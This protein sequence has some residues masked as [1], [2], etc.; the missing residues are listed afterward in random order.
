[1]NKQLSPPVQQQY[2]NI[3]NQC[4]KKIAMVCASNQNR[5][6]EAHYLFVKT[7]FKNIRSFG[8]SGH[9][10]LPGPSIHQPNIFSFGTPY[11]EI[12]TTL[13]DQDQELYIKN[14]LLNMLERNKKVKLAPEKWQEE[15]NAKFDIVFTF[16]QRVYDAVI[17]DLAQRD[18]T[19]L[20]QPVHIIN[21]QVKDTHEEA[22]GGAQHALEITSIIENTEDW[23]DKLNDILE[24]FYKSTQR[25]IL[26]TL[27]FY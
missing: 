2:F 8:T 23:E 27:M 1:M 20:M 4:T 11:S 19:T 6:L 7:G 12:Y 9:C 24:N 3:A 25:Q 13:R 5:S 22:V 14:G 18:I 10:K 21:L 26:H 15:L 16:D 17:D